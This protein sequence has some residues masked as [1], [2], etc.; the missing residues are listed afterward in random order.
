MASTELLSV[1]AEPTRRRILDLLLEQPRT[2][3]QLVGELG[4][5]QPTASKHLRVLRE[6]GLVHVHPDAQRRVY[7]LRPQPPGRAR[8]LARALPAAVGGPAGRPRGP[9]G[10][11]PRPERT[12]HDRHPRHQPRPRHPALRA[13]AAPRGR[14]GSGAP[15]PTRPS[16]AAWFPAEVIY[17]QRAG[18]P[19]QFDFG[20]AH[21][22]DAWPGE[23][24]EWDPPRVFAF[25]WGE[26]TLRFEL[27]PPG[28]HAAR[29]HPRLRPRARQAGAR[30]GRL[31][32]LLRGLRRPARRRLQDARRRRLERPP[33]ALPRP[34]RRPHDRRAARAP[35]RPLQGG[36][37]PRRRRRHHPRSPGTLVVRAAGEPLA[38][39]AAVEVRDEGGA[40]LAAGRL[41][42]PLATA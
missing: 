1:L 2:V 8:R 32:G 13:R 35:A 4:T 9:P 11:Q 31:G 17:E 40:T 15:S 5:S 25:L 7:A 10:P 26:D 37:R 18:A 27:A 28:R 3:N 29:L 16:C 30:R 41:R 39:G 36:R 14:T 12:P 20:G 6:A 33:R 24:L 19:M 38:D 34:L 42:D 22:I 21:G 23:V